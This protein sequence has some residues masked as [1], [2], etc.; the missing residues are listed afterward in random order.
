ML[1]EGTRHGLGG[2]AD[3]DEEGRVV[4]NSG[5]CRLADRGLFVRRDELPRVIFEVLDARGQDRAAVG[6]G[7][8]A[9]AAQVVEVL[10]D[11][12]GRDIEALGQVLDGDPTRLERM[13]D[14]LVQELR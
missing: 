3:V 1:Q 12:L 7:E 6:P 2:G 10:A 14:N 11:G 9:P 13:F 8:Q 4:G 5:G